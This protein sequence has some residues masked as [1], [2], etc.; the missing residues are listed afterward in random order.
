VAVGVPLIVATELE[1]GLTVRVT[2]A[3][4]GLVD[5]LYAG[6]PPEALQFA[7]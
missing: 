4:S 6:V 1:T 5:Q 7:E 2:P 3:G